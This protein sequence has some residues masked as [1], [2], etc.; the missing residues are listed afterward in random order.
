MKDKRNRLILLHEIEAITRSMLRKYIKWDPNLHKIFQLNTSEIGDLF[1]IPTK[2]AL[3]IYQCIQQI[4][5]T[6]IN[7]P[8]KSI[9][10]IYDS[11]YPTHLKMIPDPPLVLYMSGDVQ[12]LHQQ[13]SISVI[14][15]RKP[16]YEAFGKLEHII[17]PLIK[18][19][20]VIVS[21]FAYGIDSMAHRLTLQHHGKTIAVLGGG[22]NFL[23][24]KE[25]IHL[26]KDISQLGLVVTEYPPNVPPKR[27]HFPERNRIISGISN[28]T[29]VVEATER[30]GTLITV[31]QALEQGREVYAIPGSPLITQT[32][33]CHKLIQDGAKL[34]M[35]ANDITEDWP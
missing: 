9:L 35:H 30:S 10:T 28:A 31:D 8:P 34:V 14:G 29:L 19:N 21:G 12:L 5:P 33:G 15:T 32:I 26:F 13:P 25:N 18:Q 2:K 20:W 6:K 17:T 27:Y 11:D 3:L 7:H 1:N 4:N 16:S 23:Y 24:P 22:F